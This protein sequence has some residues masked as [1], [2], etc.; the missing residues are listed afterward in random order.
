M[1]KFM[2]EVTVFFGNTAKTRT[3]YHDNG[4]LFAK[5]NG[6]FV[7]VRRLVPTMTYKAV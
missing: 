2:S 4:K 3:I 5:N 1:E 7:E 6:Q